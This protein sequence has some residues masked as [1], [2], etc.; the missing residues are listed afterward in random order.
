MQETWA[1]LTVSDEGWVNPHLKSA[2]IGTESTEDLNFLGDFN[3]Q[4]Q[5]YDHT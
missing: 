4:V 3:L 1:P 2:V 5:A